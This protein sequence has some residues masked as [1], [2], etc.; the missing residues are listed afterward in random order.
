MDEGGTKGP[1]P[2]VLVTRR[3]PGPAVSR[4]QASCDVTV[5]EGPGPM[6]RPRLLEDLEGKAGALVSG[7][8]RV[9][10]EFLTAAGDGLVVVASFGVGYDHVDVEACTARGIL[11]TN[12]PDVLTEATADLTWALLMAAAR[13]VGEGERFLRRRAPWV[14]EPDFML[15]QEVSGK[16]LGIVGFGRIGQAVARRARAFSMPVLYHSRTRADASVEGAL[17]VEYRDL[18]DLMGEAD[19]VTLHTPLKPSTRHL[20]DKRRLSLMKP[21]AILVNASRGPVVDEAALVEA[22]RTGR[23]WAAGLDVYE[24][25]PEVHPGLLELE[26]VVLI[27]HLGSATVETRTAMASLAAENLLA[28]LEGRRPPC[29]VNPE[30]WDARPGL[31]AP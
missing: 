27:P 28:A 7:S 13:R 23:I 18:D 5:W 11:V 1:R 2:P 30:V 24:R 17:G 15:G 10:D 29:L 12:T 14:W 9:D 26:N 22:L 4:I 20:I 25:E 21:S 8:E 16:T 6:P 31:S 3:F 19:F